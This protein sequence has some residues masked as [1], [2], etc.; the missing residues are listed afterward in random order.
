[1]LSAPNLGFGIFLFV[2]VLRIGYRIQFGAADELNYKERL[3]SI[4]RRD[5]VTVL[6]STWTI[7]FGVVPALYFMLFLDTPP[8]ASI[9]TVRLAI[10]IGAFLLMVESVGKEPS[11]T[12]S[13]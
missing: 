10:F 1:M 13:N 7:T 3:K 8:W 12:E 2:A 4:D 5:I 9:Q 11:N 6:M